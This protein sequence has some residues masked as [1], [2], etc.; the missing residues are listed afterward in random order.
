VDRDANQLARTLTAL[1][2]A[3][4]GAGWA[5]IAAA[6]HARRRGH[7]VGLFE[8]AGELGGRARGVPVKGLVVDNGQHILIGAYSATLELMRLVGA[9]PEALLF[10]Q[11]LSLV[12]PDGSGLRLPPG[13]PVGAFIRGLFGSPGWTAADRL[14]L[15][16]C[17]GAWALRGFRCAAGLSV[18]ELCAPLTAAVRTRLIEPL[19]VAALN[20]PAAQASAAVFL[21][22]LR[23]ALFSGE[24]SSDL[25]LPRRPLSDLLPGPAR[26]WLEAQGVRIALGHRVQEIAPAP[27]GWRVADGHFDRVILACTA[28]EAARLS[29]PLAPAWA[30]A[31]AALRYEPIVTVYLHCTGVRLEQP[32]TVLR[33]RPGQP[34][35]FVFDLG[36]IGGPPGLFAFVISGAA[37]AVAAGLADSARAT[38]AQAMAAFPA[39]TWPSVPTIFHVAAEKRATF[40]CAPSLSR[41]AMVVAPGLFAAGDYVDG[42]Y[43]ATLEGAVRSGREAAWSL[44]AA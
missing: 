31:A 15:L 40:S 18:A 32:M 39:G 34:A 28:K 3:V 1:R 7:V 12:Y 36:A 43:P 6:V 42:P 11:P 24:G 41:P 37:E 44:P 13:R 5:G 38:L 33:T 35:Q 14:T 10:R 17:T 16:R 23:D 4:V 30:A 8:M 9:A 20:T 26:T 22:V 27:R 21:R 19:C 25:L 2:V 29:A